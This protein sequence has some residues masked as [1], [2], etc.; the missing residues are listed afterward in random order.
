MKSLIRYIP[1][2]TTIVALFF[3]LKMWAHW[4]KK[5][6]ARY[7]FWWLVGVAAFGLGT[8]LESLTTLIGWQESIFKLWYISGALMGGAPLALGS[9]YLLM[10]DKAANRWM[11]VMV[12]LIGVAAFCVLISPIDATLAQ[13]GRL[14]GGVLQWQW[15]RLFSPFINTFAFV[16][17]VGGAAWSAWKYWQLGDEFQNRFGGNLFIAIGCTLPAIGGASARAGHIEVLYITEFIGL[18]A[19]WLGYLIIARDGKKSVHQKQA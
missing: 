16:F 11:L 4:R 3:S 19:I 8:L 14:S 7:L 13:T 12:T 15:V 5:S 17:L 9:V 2:L 18:L 1:I 10:P 6:S